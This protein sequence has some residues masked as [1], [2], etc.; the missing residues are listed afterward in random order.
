MK[1]NAVDIQGNSKPARLVVG[2]DGSTQSRQAL[3]WAAHIAGMTH[4]PLLAVAAWEV[5][6]TLGWAAWPQG[7]DPAREAEQALINTVDEV[8]GTDRPKQLQLTV[9]EG[10]AA[11]ILVEESKGAMM[12]IVGSRG[13]GGFI[14]LLQGSVSAGV[15]EHASCPVLVVHGEAWPVAEPSADADPAAAVAAG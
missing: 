7:W 6:A 11:K 9:R 12:V 2:V 5:P 8:F 10:G 1:M 15:A 14:G 13:L 3:R 4:A